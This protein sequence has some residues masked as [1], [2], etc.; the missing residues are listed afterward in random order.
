MSLSLGLLCVASGPRTL[1]DLRTPPLNNRHSPPKAS[2]GDVNLYGMHCARQ[3]CNVCCGA[4]SCGST[5][6]HASICCVAWTAGLVLAHAS[7]RAVCCLFVGC[8]V[9]DLFAVPNTDAL[10]RTPQPLP[11]V[12]HSN[13]RSQLL[14]ELLT[15]VRLQRCAF[16]RLR[17]AKKGDPYY[18]LFV[19]LL[20]EDK[21]TAGMSY[22]E[23]LCHVHRQIQEKMG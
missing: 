10:L 13:P 7:L 2:P 1:S 15:A 4:V 19:N 11:V 18:P 3:P 9:Q 16:M 14:F 12:P 21:S 6:S 17:V 5:E 23:F 8:C 22:V 20:A